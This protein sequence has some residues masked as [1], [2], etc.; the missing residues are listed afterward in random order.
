MRDR[1]AAALAL[2]RPAA[3]ACHLRREAAFIDED[4]PFGI[5]FS[6]LFEPILARRLYIGTL[7]FTRMSGLFL[8]LMS[9]RSR[10]FQIAVD[11]TFTPRSPAR[12]AAISSSVMSGISLIRP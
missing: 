1:G 2:R 4:Q 12:R 7:L 8:C 9:C 11:T 3:Q 5:E 6:L 10:N